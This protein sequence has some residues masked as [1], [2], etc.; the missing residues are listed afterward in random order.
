MGKTPG[1]M[2]AAIA[3]NLKLRTGE[4][5]EEWVGV[6]RR[7]GPASR[8]ARVDWLMKEHGLGR[9][10]AEMITS[11]AEGQRDYSDPVALLAD[12]FAGPKAAL[13]PL[14]DELVKAATALG[15]D[16]QVIPCRTQVTLRRKRQFAWIKASTRTR[17]DL[18]LALPG[19]APGGRLLPVAGTNDQDRVRLRI[20][21]ARSDEIDLELKR[22]L[23]AAYDLDER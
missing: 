5:I 19:V 9:V 10:A 3:W 16:V 15:G 18:G 14:Y 20:A 7:S 2:Q 21:V 11:C 12:I 23:K 1:E 8:K 17:L 13:L 6:V 22:W 4:S